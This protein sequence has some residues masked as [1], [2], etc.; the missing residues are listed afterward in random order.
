MVVLLLLLREKRNQPLKTDTKRL[1]AA[2]TR[3]SGVVDVRVHVRATAGTTAEVG[4]GVVAATSSFAHAR[5]AR[6]GHLTPA[7]PGTPVAVHCT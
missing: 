2:V 1:T 3:H 5:T 6:G 4:S 7:F